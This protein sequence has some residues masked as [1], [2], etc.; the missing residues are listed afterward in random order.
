M[1]KAFVLTTL[2]AVL[3]AKNEIKFQENEQEETRIKGYAVDVSLQ[4][5]IQYI[6]HSFC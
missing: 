4:K 3:D 5:F 6:E 1:I 2:F